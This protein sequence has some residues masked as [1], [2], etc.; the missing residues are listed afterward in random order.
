MWRLFLSGLFCLPA[1]VLLVVA[2]HHDDA[3]HG[4][5]ALPP[6]RSAVARAEGP[7]IA[8]SLPP[9]QFQAASA[10]I[11]LDR[12]AFA[13]TDFA[14]APTL[15]EP[16]PSHPKLH[17]RAVVHRVDGPAPSIPKSPQ[18]TLWG[19]IGHWFAQHEVQKPGRPAEAEAPGK[20][21]LKR[22]GTPG[23]GRHGK[24]TP[25]QRGEL[26]PHGSGGG[27]GARGRD[28]SFRSGRPAE[29]RDEGA[30]EVS[31][32]RRLKGLGWGS[33]RI[34][35][36]LGCSRN[37]VRYWVA[38]GDWRRC[39]S[40]SRSKKLDGLSEWLRERV[41]RHAGNAEVERPLAPL[42]RELIA[43]ARALREAT[44]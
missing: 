23:V 3:L 42:R 4:E 11:E 16:V 2:P 37:T 41:R 43:A 35:A 27:F 32:M 12:W 39:A 19:S 15:R 38:R 5:Y 36:E 26:T 34:A 14:A 17:A 8:I 31:A 44:G 10:P 33:K 24:L 40:P 22:V 7:L 18:G 29:G 21:N 9:R 28:G 13:S 6:S 25:G 1:L 30:D 20:Q